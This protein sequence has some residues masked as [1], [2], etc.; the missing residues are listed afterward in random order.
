MS[1]LQYVQDKIAQS[2]SFIVDG[3]EFFVP[4][5]AQIDLEAEKKKLEEELYY[6]QGFLKSV[7][8]KLQNQKFMAGAPEMVVSNERKKEAD[9]LA[10]MAILKEKLA[11]L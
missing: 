10:K 9:A 6:T 7:Q 2:N 3:I 8:A 5:G 11:G 1:T 4:F